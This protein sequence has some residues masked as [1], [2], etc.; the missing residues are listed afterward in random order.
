MII[1][2]AVLMQVDITHIDVA[3]V[4]AVWLLKVRNVCY[5]SSLCRHRDG[6]VPHRG[7]VN[8]TSLFFPHKW[9]SR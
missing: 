1:D 8:Y 9:Q 7:Q 3:H 5:K 2:P 6:M 4:Y